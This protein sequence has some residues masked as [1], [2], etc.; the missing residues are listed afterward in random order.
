MKVTELFESSPV[1]KQG[2]VNSII[3]ALAQKLIKT[4]ANTKASIAALLRDT[5]QFW[6]SELDDVTRELEKLPK[7]TG[8]EQF[9]DAV[10]AA[11][12]AVLHSMV[13]YY[14]DSAN[15]EPGYKVP[16]ISKPEH[17]QV[18]VG[19]IDKAFSKFQVLADKVKSEKDATKAAKTKDAEKLKAALTPTAIAAI[20][21]I[22][23]A[24]FVK[25]ISEAGLAKIAKSPKRYGFEE[26]FAPK[27]AAQLVAGVAKTKS[28]KQT[29]EQAMLEF[30]LADNAA[31][32]KVAKYVGVFSLIENKAATSVIVN[33]TTNLKK[34]LS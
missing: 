2:E 6:V 18:P 24:A 16:K 29:L 13:E 19:V 22:A 4:D 21:K 5:D 32:S 10:D 34:A 3:Y 15:H 12:D 8:L 33:A 30:V 1:I 31:Y 26:G 25:V 27:S 11:V 17:V 28:A 7:R 9:Y 14:T 20:A 23:D